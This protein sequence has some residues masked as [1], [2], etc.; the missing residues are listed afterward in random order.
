M[1]SPADNAS[2]RRLVSTL[3]ILVAV[4]GVCGRI[5]AVA[6]VYEPNFYKGEDEVD[7]SRSVWPKKPP[8]PMPTLGD[9]D[10]SRWDTVRSLVDEGKYAIGDREFDVTTNPPQPVHDPVT[11]KPIDHGIVTEDGWRTIDKVLDPDKHQFYSSKPPFLATLLAGEYWLLKETLGWEITT[12]RYWVV[13]TLLLTINAL[14][15]LVYLILLSR[16]LEQF[17][18]TDWGRLFVLTTACF[19]TLISPFLISLNNHTVGAFSALFALYFT[20]TSATRSSPLPSNIPTLPL[21]HPPAPPLLHAALAGFFAGFT[22]SNEMPAGCFVVGLFLWWL[23]ERRGWSALLVFV[24]AA[25]VPVGAF[26]FTNERASGHLLGVYGEFGGDW[27]EYEGS[28]WKVD[29]TKP[30]VGIDWASDKEERAAYAFHLLIGHHG[31][32]ALTPVFL[33]ALAGMVR[34]LF[35]R[36]GE[37]AKV[38]WLALAATIILLVFYIFYVPDRNR[39]YGGWTCGPRWLLWLTPLFLLTLLPVADWLAGR[40]WGRVFGYTLLAVSVLSASYPAWN[41]WRHPWLYNYFTEMQWI[42]Y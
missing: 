38:G 41:P 24:L 27:Y 17:G 40:R 22:V 36:R 34:A 42:S 3:L 37:L 14:P 19:G 35:V 30:K 10:R 20:L 13:R 7:P 16:L 23:L 39:N 15:F 12:D 25:A 2:L 9:N 5:L 4:A 26:V 28:Y 18:M 6:R 29:P 31:L 21:S 33:L 8:Q 1:N 32:F 11:G